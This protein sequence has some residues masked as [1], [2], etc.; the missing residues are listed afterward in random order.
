[1]GL[2][3]GIDGRIVLGIRGGVVVLASVL[4]V[5]GCGSQSNQ[6][7]APAS[8]AAAPSTVDLAALDVGNYPTKPQPALGAAG[9]DFKG[10]LADARRMADFVV[11][12]WDVDPA[13][14]GSYASTAMV[15][16]SADALALMGDKAVAAAAGR[17][18]FV[19]GFYS[20]RKAPDQTILINGVLRYT[21]DA[22]ATAAAADIT[23]TLLNEPASG[24]TRTRVPIPGHPDTSTSSY[25]FTDPTVG[26]EQST[27]EALTPHG[28]YVLIQLAQSYAGQDATVGLVAKTLDL[29]TPL[30]DQFKPTPVGDFAGVPLDPTGLLART[31]LLPA[32]DATV[33]QNWVYQPRGALHFQTDPAATALFTDTGTDAVASGKT[34]VYQTADAAGATKLAAA[35]V[36]Q[37]TEANQGKPADPVKGLPGTTCLQ[38]PDVGF[39]C[40]GTRDRYVIEAQTGQLPDAHQMV[41]AQYAMLAAK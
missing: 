1:M 13:L 32:K 38:S 14:T 23:D 37:V 3:A 29:Q 5:V 36:K 12:P 33:V 8:S 24:A 34:T 19:N 27:V 20:A 21:D 10:L 35:F 31:L 11:G 18:P 26:K 7:S 9:T 6:G 17:H 28:P 30:I 39:Y 15:L 41:A 40:T 2:L 4:L 16:K 22:A 25:R